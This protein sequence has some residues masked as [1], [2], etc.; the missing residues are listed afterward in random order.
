MYSMPYIGRLKELANGEYLA[1]TEIQRIRE[2]K[3]RIL[4]GFIQRGRETK[5]EK[6]NDGSPKPHLLF[7][8]G[9]NG[10]VADVV[11]SES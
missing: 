11:L 7:P 6:S 8:V 5:K 4:S 9:F 2:L 3:D 10:N 1:F